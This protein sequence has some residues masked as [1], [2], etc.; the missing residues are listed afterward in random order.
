M[1]GRQRRALAR[2]ALRVFPVRC[3]ALLRMRQR[4][5]RTMRRGA[6]VMYEIAVSGT[7]MCALERRNVRCWAKQQ[8]RVAT[9]PS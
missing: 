9:E 1:P 8:R 3:S 2:V 5:C 4:V 7:I 6:C